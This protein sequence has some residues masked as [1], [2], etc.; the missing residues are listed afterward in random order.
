[1]IE[2]CEGLDKIE[3]LQNHENDEVYKKALELIE[4]FF[5][6]EKDEQVSHSFKFF[7]RCNK[8]KSRNFSNILIYDYEYLRVFQKKFF[9]SFPILDTFIV[10]NIEKYSHTQKISS[11]C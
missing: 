11:K 8:Q 7:K 1:M 10:N 3:D 6:D 5:N 4:T 2:E 9:F